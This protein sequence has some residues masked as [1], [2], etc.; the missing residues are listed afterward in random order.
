[1]S[2]MWIIFGSLAFATSIASYAIPVIR[3]VEIILPD[4]DQEIPAQ[5]DFN[6][7][8]QDL[9]RTRQ[10]LLTT[11]HSPGRERALK[12]ISNELRELGR[13]RGFPST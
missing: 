13:R 7:Q 10:R 9:L 12:H 3:D 11:P 5:E 8:L 2:L 1:M 6:T 4:H